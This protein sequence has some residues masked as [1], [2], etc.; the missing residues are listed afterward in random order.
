MKSKLLNKRLGFESLE[1]RT[2]M[3]GN[4][5]S[6]QNNGFLNLC[7]DAKGD[8]F[9]VRQT[10]SGDW[11]VTGINKTKIDGQKS[12]TFSDV[13]SINIKTLGGNDVVG[14]ATGCLPGFLCVDTGGGNDLVA[15]VALKV[16]CVSVSTG[17]GNDA[18]IVAGLCT[19][20]S[21]PTTDISP[22]TTTSQSPSACF[23]VGCGTNIVL[24]AAIKTD[25][26]SLKSGN[27]NDYIGLAG[28]CVDGCLSVD[29]GTGI[30]LLGIID[31]HARF[32]KL[33]GGSQ[34]GD[35]LATGQNSFC[36]TSS[37]F[38]V[39]LN[40][41]PLVKIINTQLKSVQ[42]TMMSSLNLSALT[43]LPPLQI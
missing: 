15:L 37:D 29:T 7:G 26:L 21:T 2:L 38:N 35:L 27:G 16:G 1:N 24:L 11:C 19:Q 36:Q 5:V 42:K 12:Q 17:A 25:S 18:L 9:L 20:S 14:V 10:S 13:C 39:T 34:P 32:A 30:D 4:V 43:T 33:C 8:Q 6:F 22:L 28:V 3:A 41:D 31:S 23:D 40:L